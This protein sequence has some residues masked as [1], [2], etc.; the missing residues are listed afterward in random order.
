MDGWMDVIFFS[1]E[2][3][4]AEFKRD[5]L[6]LLPLF[7]FSSS[8]SWPAL[9]LL[10]ASQALECKHDQR[11]QE[12]LDLRFLGHLYLDGEGSQCCRKVDIPLV[13]GFSRVF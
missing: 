3:E 6:G 7:L 10:G 13:C 11:G 4:H 9:G 1:K 2:T 8:M 12:L 5:G